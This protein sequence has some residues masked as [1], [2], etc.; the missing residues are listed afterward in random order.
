[1][2]HDKNIDTGPFCPILQLIHYSMIRQR[3]LAVPRRVGR[4]RRRIDTEP[5]RLSAISESQYRSS[6]TRCD[7]LSER[8]STEL[9]LGPDT[10]GP[11]G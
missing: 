1:M 6:R 10:Q 11:P 4:L 5:A 2:R 3:V 7:E 9:R 8:P